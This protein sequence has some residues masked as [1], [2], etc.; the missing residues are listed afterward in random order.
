MRRYGGVLGSG[1]WIAG[2]HHGPVRGAVLIHRHNP[3]LLPAIA[4][5]GVIARNGK[6]AELGIHSGIVRAGKL[7]SLSGNIPAPVLKTV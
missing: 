6:H 4:Y 1:T 7:W 3:R 2:I 5:F